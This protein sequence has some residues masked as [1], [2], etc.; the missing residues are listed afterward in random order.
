[1]KFSTRKSRV[2]GLLEGEN[3]V[4]LRLIVSN[5][6]RKNPEFADFTHLMALQVV[7]AV[8]F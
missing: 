8:N 1:M 7:T 4:L 2:P 3:C 6:Y 5:R